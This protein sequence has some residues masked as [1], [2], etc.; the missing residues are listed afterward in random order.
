LL[1]KKNGSSSLLSALLSTRTADAK[2]SLNG[3][4][5]ATGD[6]D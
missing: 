5:T 2:K 4:I 6:I 3:F 1:R